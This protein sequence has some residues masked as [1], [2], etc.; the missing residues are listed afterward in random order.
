M[1]ALKESPIKQYLPWR[2]QTLLEMPYFTMKEIAEFFS[3][4]N[5]LEEFH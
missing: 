1:Q 3:T 4:S 5:F 2:E